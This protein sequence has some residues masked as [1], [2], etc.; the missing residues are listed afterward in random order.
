[1]AL[2]GAGGGGGGARRGREGMRGGGDGGG[3]WGR[4]VE[5]GG[6]GYLQTQFHNYN[7]HKERRLFK[8][9]CYPCGD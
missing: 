2:G 1:M 4:G 3:D 7:V 6:R 9:S 8:C 5:R